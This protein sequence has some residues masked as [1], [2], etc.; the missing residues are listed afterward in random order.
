MHTNH[1]YGEVT[2]YFQHLEEEH[3]NLVFNEMLKILGGRTWQ[4]IV[5]GA[6]NVCTCMEMC[7][8]VEESSHSDLTA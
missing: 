8:A 7:L 4:F 3:G 1:S 2:K 5:C 6:S